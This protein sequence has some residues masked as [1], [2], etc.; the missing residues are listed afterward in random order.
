MII[1]VLAENLSISEE[2]TPEHGLC[3]YIETQSHK[4]LFDLGRGELF[5]ENAK[6]M[7]VNLAGVDVAFISHG[8]YDHGGGL[9][10]FLSINQKANVYLHERAFDDYYSK[11]PNGNAYIGLDKAFAHDKR[12][13]FTK[14]FLRIN[15]EISLF[16]GVRGR[17]LP[18]L[19]NKFL[20]EKTGD[21]FMEDQFEHEQNLIISEKGKTVIF[22]GCAHN[23]IVNVLNRFFE[24]TGRYP[25]SVIGGFHLFNP[26]NG[27]AESQELISAIAKRLKSTGSHCYTCHCTG[28]GPYNQ[29]KNILE[30][31][32]SYLATGSVVKI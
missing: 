32:L 14:G 28:E 24:I 22:A 23:G 13:I 4:L 8:H 15:E 5:L 19:S 26:L 6:K 18:T 7:D 10:H 29:M 12:I 31:R 11:R 20:L 25:D 17:E 30:E 3:L 2:Y 1:R 9:A 27:D 16:S 21:G